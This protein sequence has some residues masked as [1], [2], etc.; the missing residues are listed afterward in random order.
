MYAMRRDVVNV[1]SVEDPVENVIPM[2][3]HHPVNEGLGV[4]Y[5]MLLRGILRHDPD[6]IMVGEIRDSETA[7]ITIRAAETGHHVFTSLHTN[8]APETISRFIEQ[9]PVTS[10]DMGKGSIAKTIRAV[11]NQRLIRKL[12]ECA[13]PMRV[14]DLEASHRRSMLEIGMT[15]K[16]TIMTPGS[17]PKCNGVGYRGRVAVIDAVFVPNNSM[18]REK[19]Q[20][21]IFEQS[22]ISRMLSLDGIRH[23]KRKDWNFEG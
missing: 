23:F 10:R 7:E 5:A 6:V 22:G 20:T 15:D 2:V 16:E 13:V 4:T 12:C 19:M 18:L 17:C 1:D 21:V 3:R 14:I 11:I 9:L 8:S